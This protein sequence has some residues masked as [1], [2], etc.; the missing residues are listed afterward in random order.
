MAH[1]LAYLITFT[2]YGS[3]LHGGEP[4]SVDRNQRAFGAR[5][6]APDV[7]RRTAAE[8]RMDTAACS[9][10]ASHRAM[11]LQAIQETCVFRGWTLIVAHVR[12]SHVHVIVEAEQTP[13]QVMHDLK[14]YA[15]RFLNQ[16]EGTRSKRWTRHGSTRYLW[17]DQDV[18]N[19]VRYVM[20]GTAP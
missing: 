12:S 14:A 8:E 18:V 3:H 11:V 5:Y 4:G 2:C 9:L 16:C 10:A 20:C 7:S 19:A 6:V 15:T 13:E 17:K 1:P